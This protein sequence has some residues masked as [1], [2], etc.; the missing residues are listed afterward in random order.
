MNQTTSMDAASDATATATGAAAP[1]RLLY[2][3]D[4]P[5]EA[6]YHG[7]ALLYRLLE[8]YPKERLTIVEAG[9]LASLPERRLSD[10]AYYHRLMPFV[11]LQSTRL[12]PWYVAAGL[13]SAALRASQLMPLA[14]ADRPE[15]ILTVAHGYSWLTAAALAERLNIAL[16]LICHDE[17]ARAGVMQH[18]KE[19]VFGGI[20]RRAASRLCVSPF[21]A[22]E[23]ERRYGVPGDVL[24]P[25]RALDAVCYDGPPRR[26]SRM[27]KPFTCVFAGTI[28]SGGIVSLLRQLAAALAMVGGRL[29]I[30]GPIS[31]EAALASSL[32]GPNIVLGGLLP[33]A[34]LIEV[35]RDEADALFVP[36]SFA[37]ADRANMRI[38]FP[39][40]LTDYTAAALPLLIC[41]PE[42][43]SAVRWARENPG[44]AEV[45]SHEAEAAMVAAVTR[46]ANEP[47]HRLALA[48]RAMAVGEAMFS[49]AAAAR[50]L[51]RALHGH[52]EVEQTGSGRSGEG[53][54]MPPAEIGI[55]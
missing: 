26:L 13:R 54:A 30:Y 45:V 29:V 43:C 20:Y 48:T 18:W 50:V 25:S 36:M 44:V 6:S 53:I 42:D 52:V 9:T 49:H 8:D 39:S 11:R 23:Y 10:V 24:Y 33:S 51:M 46:L 40:K 7:S 37:E 4:V 34:R 31:E 2:L 12:H 1:P 55:R 41:G 21:M 32:V 28:N 38:S 47:S 22:E 14:Q 16:H 3:A 19:K 35:M 15:A 5:V 27:D 17:W